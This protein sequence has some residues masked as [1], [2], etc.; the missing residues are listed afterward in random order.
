MDQRVSLYE[1]QAVLHTDIL[2]LQEN[3]ESAVDLLVTESVGDGNF[4]ARLTSTKTDTWEV[5][6]DPGAVYLDGKRY[7]LRTNK[8]LD[9]FGIR[10]LAQKKIIAIIGTGSVIGS[11][12]ELRDFATDAEGTSWEP[13][14]VATAALRTAVVEAQPGVEAAVPEAPAT[15]VGAV[16]IAL[17]TLGTSGVETVEMQEQNLLPQSHRLELAID[18]LDGFK[19]KTEE[20]LASLRSDLAALGRDVAT[21]ALK[22]TVSENTLRIKQLEEIGARNWEAL[23]RLAEEQASASQFLLHNFDSFV[24]DAKSDTDHGD[25]AARING[26]LFFPLA[27]GNTIPGGIQ[28]NTPNDAKVTV[29][30]NM[31]CP[32]VSAAARTLTTGPAIIQYVNSQQYSVVTH[33]KQQMSRWT[34][35]ANYGSGPAEY[36]YTSFTGVPGV[37]WAAQANKPT[38]YRTSGQQDGVKWNMARYDETAPGSGQYQITWVK[39]YDDWREEIYYADETT[40]TT[41]DSQG[42]AQ[43]IMNANGGWLRTVKFWTDRASSGDIDVVVCQCDG[44]GKPDLQ[45]ILSEVTIQS[46][47]VVSGKNSVPIDQ[48][49][50]A[51]GQQFGIV[52]MS[53]GAYQ[54]EVTSRSVSNGQHYALTAANHFDVPGSEGEADLRLQLDFATYEDRTVFVD[55]KPLEL[56]GGMDSVGFNTPI[57]SPANCSVHFEVQHNGTWY[58]MD[59]GQTTASMDWSQ[60]PN[61][62]QFRVVFKGTADAMPS[63]G[64]NS[65]STLI[66]GLAATDLVHISE[67][68]DVGVGNTTSE[69]R[70]RARVDN[71]KEADHD[72]TIS[73]IAG[74]SSIAASDVQDSYIDND[75]LYRTAIFNGV[76]ATQT[77]Q[78]KMEGSTNDIAKPFTVVDRFDYA[79]V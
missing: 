19:V 29:E 11:E 13:R 66:V 72:L 59:P 77:F 71:F 5:T 76:T 15:P 63:I 30:N 24:S 42:R 51:P 44:S 2:K 65:L 57:V 8:V 50:F 17:I 1:D 74:G 36:Q 78:V 23:Q 53:T 73:L 56:A 20:A 7:R 41:K 46:A 64:I 49:Y 28:L 35:A 45:Q 9:T 38:N 22:S 37:S 4:Y 27:T 16:L 31:M 43:T 58:R 79:A 10:P 47:N 33:T 62:L 67:P 48:V 12:P 39:V 61:L 60:K 40:T 52:L 55:L 21:R 14:P 68:V 6:I 54:F 26:G 69:I 75:T 18:E 70:V 3:A 32:K 25:Y 34:N